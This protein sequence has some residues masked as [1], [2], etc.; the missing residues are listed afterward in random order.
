MLLRESDLAAFDRVFKK[1]NFSTWRFKL[2][3]KQEAY[4]GE[5]KMRLSII[6]IAPVPFIQESHLLLDHMLAIK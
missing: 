3:A 5:M 4:Q 2:R 6:S 1:A